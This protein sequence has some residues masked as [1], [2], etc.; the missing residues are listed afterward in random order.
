MEQAKIDGHIQ[1]TEHDH[2]YINLNNKRQYISCTTVIGQYFPKFKADMKNTAKTRRMFGMT[3]DEVVDMW[4]KKRIHS[5]NRGSEIH[6]GQEM[7]FRG[8]ADKAA[9]NPIHVSKEEYDK[10]CKF[11]W[12]YWYRMQEEGWQFH[13][14]EILAG[15][16]EEL[17][18][19]ADLPMF[20]HATKE[21]K[22]IDF[23]TNEKEL[24]YSSPYHTMLPPFESMGGGELTKY[25]IQLAIY[26]IL[27]ERKYPE[28]KVT[29]NQIWHLRDGEITLIDLDMTMFR[30]V[31]EEILKRRRNEVCGNIQQS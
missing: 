26:S 5:C 3:F 1:F 16:E 24:L 31:A 14:E 10:Y 7:I 20:N 4:D 28:Y 18:G 15:D 22:L 29:M 30:P 11:G 6:W 13:P 19:Q 2:K 9:I 8:T 12:D 27:L 23:K 17:A 21:I 25:G